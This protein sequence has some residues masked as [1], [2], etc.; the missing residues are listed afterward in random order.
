VPLQLHCATAEGRAGAGAP[1]KQLRLENRFGSFVTQARSTF[2]VKPFGVAL[3]GTVWG[4]SRTKEAL[5]STL[6]YRKVFGMVL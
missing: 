2:I 5:L 4:W 3:S 1:R 6:I